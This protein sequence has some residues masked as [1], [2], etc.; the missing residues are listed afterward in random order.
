MDYR[1]LQRHVLCFTLYNALVCLMASRGTAAWVSFADCNK[2]VPE[3]HTNILAELGVLTGDLVASQT[4]GSPW[5]GLGC[6]KP[7]Q[8]LHDPSTWLWGS[9]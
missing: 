6:E 9:S 1:I 5:K 8:T 7:L 4:Q 3:R 2:A